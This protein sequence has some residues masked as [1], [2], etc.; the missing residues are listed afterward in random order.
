VLAPTPFA[1]QVNIRLQQCCVVLVGVYLATPVV[2]WRFWCFLSGS[3]IGITGRH[4]TVAPCAGGEC[5]V[6]PHGP[7][8]A[9]GSILARNVAAAVTPPLDM[10]V[11]VLAENRNGQTLQCP[12]TLPPLTPRRST[13]QKQRAAGDAW[14]AALGNSCPPPAGALTVSQGLLRRA[15]PSARM[16]RKHLV[17]GPNSR[18]YTALRPLV[19][20]W[21]QLGTPLAS[22][23]GT[24]A[25]A[26][27]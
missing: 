23:G 20:R 3:W 18:D 10:S 21:G 7:D 4:G 14:R 9:G 13:H 25:N 12:F 6:T 17:G 2:C 27:M 11:P 5:A 26:L 1:H 24:L 19:G 8:I 16:G 15:G 22:R